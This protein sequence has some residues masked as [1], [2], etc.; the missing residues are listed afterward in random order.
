M[1]PS[2]P[3]AWDGIVDG[4]KTFA[5]I[6]AFAIEPP[7]VLSVSEW[8]EAKRRVSPESGSPYPGASSN[9]CSRTGTLCRARP[10]S[11]PS[12]SR[13][14]E[15]N[16]SSHGGGEMAEAFGIACHELVSLDFRCGSCVTSAARVAAKR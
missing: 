5:R 7:P 11:S 2:R 13:S 16:R 9:T 8:A 10:R 4:A 14:A 6:L 1:P 3:N 12:A 15:S